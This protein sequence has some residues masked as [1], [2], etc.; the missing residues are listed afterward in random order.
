MMSTYNIE[1]KNSKPYKG[2]QQFMQQLFYNYASGGLSY[3]D[4]AVYSKSLPT[5]VIAFFK[6]KDAAQKNFWR[7]FIQAGRAIMSTDSVE[8]QMNFLRNSC[9]LFRF[10]VDENL[11]PECYFNKITSATTHQPKRVSSA[12]FPHW[13]LTYSTFVD[14]LQSLLIKE[15]QEYQRLVAEAEKRRKAEPETNNFPHNDSWSYKQL[16]NTVIIGERPAE[17]QTYGK[18]M[19]CL[20]KVSNTHFIDS[21]TF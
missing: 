18:M 20:S 5:Q 1:D 16:M 2:L 7:L 15:D 12:P 9:D 11:A 6:S 17:E 13:L 19:K 3:L 10:I 8:D 4:E 21:Y 14:Y